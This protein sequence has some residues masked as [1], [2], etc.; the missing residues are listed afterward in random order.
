M[1]RYTAIF[2]EE[3]KEL[4][5]KKEL[6]EAFGRHHSITFRASYDEETRPEAIVYFPVIRGPLINFPKVERFI[7]N[8]LLV[9]VIPGME[10][11]LSMPELRVNMFRHLVK[12]SVSTSVD[13][14]AGEDFSAS[15][16]DT[17]KAL[18]HYVV[19]IKVQYAPDVIEDVK[20]FIFGRIGEPQ[21]N[22]IRRQ[23]DRFSRV[24]L[25]YIHAEEILDVSG[26]RLASIM[27]AF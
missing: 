17:E 22:I 24:F 3:Q 14:M 19:T 10:S 8:V 18:P 20:I 13:P 7:T 23:L 1:I 5:E 21:L 12:N 9:N 6:N 11:M 26:Q 25:K 16:I 4:K 2:Q 27:Q 15:D